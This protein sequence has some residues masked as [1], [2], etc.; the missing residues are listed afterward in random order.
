MPADL[1]ID[2]EFNY[3]ETH[4]Q[5]LKA[6]ALE[7][8]GIHL[9]DTKREMIYSRI[10][11]IIRQHNLKSF[12]EYCETLTQPTPQII[13]DFINAI[14]TKLTSFMRENH[15]FTYLQS[16]ILPEIIQANEKTRRARIWSA[17]CSS[18][19]EPYSI[20]FFVYNEFKDKPSWDVKILATDIDEKILSVCKEGVYPIEEIKKSFNDLEVNTYFIKDLNKLNYCQVKNEYKNLIHFKMMNLMDGVWPMRGQFDVIFCRN[21]LIY[22]AREKQIELIKR[23]TS[24]IAP[25]GYL[26]LG[27]SESAPSGISDLK[28]IQKTIYRRI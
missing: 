10:S 22:F 14:T 19:E 23:F 15:H 11:R 8:T 25:G 18:G 6:K 1:E 26:I 9:E 2:K 7:M 13:E 12:N 28:F 4:F 21:V 16:N 17:G 27:H 20:S 24:M 5:F 3:T